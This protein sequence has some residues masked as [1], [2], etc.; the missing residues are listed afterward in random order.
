[1]D[2][3]EREVVLHDL[4]QALSDAV[5]G[6]GRVALIS[7][8]AG[9][10]KSALVREFARKKPGVRRVL[11]SACDALFTPRP[12]G[13]VH[14]IA[15]QT[16][17]PL[18][19][20]LSRRA[21]RGAIFNA[22]LAELQSRPL[23]VVVEDIHW[24]DEATLDL[25][26]FLG[27]RISQTTALLLLT[28][29]DD[30]LNQTHPLR[31]VLGDLAASRA[32]LRIALAPLSQDAVQV[33]VGDRPIDAAAL[34]QQTGGNPFFVTEVLSSGG[35]GLPRTVRDAV[36]GRVAR[37]SSAAR[38]ALE[39]AA[40]VGPRIEPAL[41]ASMV[42][43]DA[44]AADE[45]LAG[46]VLV[47]QRDVLEFRHEL[48]R[49]I[50]LEAIQPGRRR[51]LHR[52]ALDALRASPALAGDLTR[53]AHHAEGAGDRQAILS[54]APA[55]ARQAASAGAHRA[56][57]ALYALAL[58]EVADAAAEERAEL[59][60]AHA[61]EAAHLADSPG[62]VASLRQAVEL[63]RASGNVLKQGASL[64]N[65]AVALYIGGSRAEARQVSQDAVDLLSETPGREL[66]LAYSTHALFDQ[67]R[68]DLVDA[69][70]MAER[71][72][73]L[74][75]QAG[76]PSTLAQA[77]TRLG[78]ST[79][80]IDFARGRQFLEHA[81]DIALEA[82]FDSRVASAYANLSSGAV[83]LFHLDYAEAV[84]AEGLAYSA[85]RDL[86]RTRLYMLAWQATLL[87]HRGHYAAA[88]SAASEVLRSPI[89]SSNARFAALLTL[90]RLEARRGDAPGRESWLDQALQL[91]E[92]LDV[93]QYLGPARAARAEAAWLAGNPAR[94]R[95]EAEAA[96]E[97]ALDKRHTWVAAELAFWRWRAGATDSPP[98][99]IA[100]P[101]AL[102]IGGDWHAAAAAWRDLGCPYEAAQALADGD[103]TA[104]AEALLIL[105]GLDARPA[106]TAL[107]RAMRA[108]GIVGLPR[109]PRQTTRANRYGLTS[110]QVEILQLLAEGLSNPEIGDRLSI[111]PKTA[112]H[113]V[114]AVLAKL[115]V[116][117]RRAAV[118]L[119]IT[120]RLID[121]T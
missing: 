5:A 93:V 115:D 118:K 77:Y 90:G 98:D 49:Q 39:A 32:A 53:L 63:W 79:M 8:E 94:A 89:T 87:L 62:A 59:L 86:D 68:H 121:Q 101:Y 44:P 23:I 3:L 114:A 7:G 43:E 34:H 1:M 51:R 12:L 11:W 76:D 9:L 71:A 41:L 81:R 112:E 64:A 84:L 45:C 55:A 38:A 105:D 116:P 73:P 106:A 6:Q 52:L 25:L 75:E 24:A 100:R 117:S 22:A 56:A 29:R 40:V 113:H 99:W 14:D 78:T 21:D 54:Y 108:R 65:L 107:R 4:H 31:P 103:A 16:D 13:P 102:H 18:S 15:E 33:L 35:G 111:S 80:F 30:E 46:G 96:F 42:P 74:A 67:S 48:A 110:R 95:S 92:R 36:L 27:R 19:A 97:L 10:G 50:V 85:D 104:Q 47:V 82:G 91:A 72:I 17:G 37:L 2:L 58:N 120:Q 28:Y 109:G 26:R 119:A 66:A 61:A 20:L 60:D 88:R 57:V 83:E 70:A 69:I